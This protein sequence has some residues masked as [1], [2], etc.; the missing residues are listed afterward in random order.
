MA[1]GALALLA[2]CGDDGGGNAREPLAATEVAPLASANVHALA[3]AWRVG[4]AWSADAELVGDMLGDLPIVGA[5]PETGGDPD[6][7]FDARLDDL[8]DKL[9]SEVFVAE[10]VVSDDGMT[11]V[12]ELP[13]SMVCWDEESRPE[14]Q[15]RWADEP[16]RL[17][18]SSRA[19]GELTIDLRVGD[20][21]VAPMTFTVAPERASATVSLAPLLALLERT[22]ALD[23][24]DDGLAIDELSG[25]VTLAIAKVGDHGV[26]VSA[27]LDQ[28]LALRASGQGAVVTASVGR[29]TASATFDAAARTVDVGLDVGA[30]ALDAPF[31]LLMGDDGAGVSLATKLQV[32]VPGVTAD[33][34]VDD[35]AGT[36]DVAGFGLGTRQTTVK[37]GG[38]T[39]LAL[40]LNPGAG[41]DVDMH[42]VALGD[43]AREISVSPSLELRV[44]LALASLASIEPGFDAGW[45]NSETLTIR[46]DGAPAPTV[47][48]GADG[49]TEIVAGKLTYGSTAAP[50]LGFTAS[51]GQCV[52]SPDDDGEG[53]GGEDAHPFASLTVTSCER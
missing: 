10:N 27:A 46:L 33:L 42:L 41:R 21:P 9:A 35:A 34:F 17:A 49:V 44:K 14:C 45:A 28:A 15:A 26:T 13:L 19:E 25:K 23:A 22:G 43:G 7:A 18:V 16:V 32:D 37:V 31:A 48:S 24:G 12:Y 50:E 5:D 30:I 38:S 40:D 47:R 51:A 1:L 36:V 3:T 4:A 52:V 29:S 6:R 53:D 2:A 11:I 20:P 39:I 8:A